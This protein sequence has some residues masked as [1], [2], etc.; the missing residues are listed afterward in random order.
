[1]RTTLAA[2]TLVWVM[3][4]GATIGMAQAVTEKSFR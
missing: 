1:M 4:V 3:C 2:I